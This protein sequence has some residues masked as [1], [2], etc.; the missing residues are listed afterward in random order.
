MSEERLL[1]V[2]QDIADEMRCFRLKEYPDTRK[3]RMELHERDYLRNL[4]RI[5]R[6]TWNRLIGS[7]VDKHTYLNG[8]K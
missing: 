1:D 3:K 2:L 4:H 8:S 5:E 7:G 6:D